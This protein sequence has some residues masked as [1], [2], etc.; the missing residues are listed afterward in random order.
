MTEKEKMFAGMIY[1]ANNDAELVDR[2]Q[3]DGVPRPCHFRGAA[4]GECYTIS[5]LKV[6][7]V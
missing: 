7:P 6:S 2:R 1:D 4:Y 5:S 3:C